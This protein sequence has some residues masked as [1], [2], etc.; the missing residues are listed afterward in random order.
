M[1]QKMFYTD[2]YYLLKIRNLFGYEGF[3]H[4]RALFSD[5]KHNLNNN[6]DIMCFKVQRNR[7]MFILVM[8]WILVQGMF[9]A[10]LWKEIILLTTFSIS[11]FIKYGLM[12]LYEKIY[13]KYF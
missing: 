9:I 6:A 1:D 3:C 5:I 7:N 4:Y 2:L 12:I 8:Y 10:S 13:L 11:S